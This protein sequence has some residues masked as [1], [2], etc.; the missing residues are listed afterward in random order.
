M[1]DYNHELIGR[2]AEQAALDQALAAVRH[3]SGGIVLLAGAAGVGKTW[4]LD[5]C[6]DRSGL[7]VLRGRAN[8]IATPP[9]GP[10]AGALR[11]YLRARPDGLASTGPLAPYLALLLPELGAPPPD[12]DPAVLVE[13]VCQAFTAIA[14]GTPPVL[15]LDDLQWADNATLELVPALASALEH[16]RVLVVG[17]YRN[18]EIGRGHP[19]RRLRNDLRRAHF[20]REIVVEPL[21]RAETTALAARTFGR[22]P[23]P[24]LAATLYDRTEG[25]PLFVRELAGALALRGRL[26]ASDAGV[27]L[28]PGQDMPIPDTLR[29]AVLLRLDGLPDPALRLLHLAAVAGREFDLAMV[30]ELGGDVEG[31]TEGFDTLFE[32][33]LLVEAEPGR[34]AFRHTL[35]REAVYGDIS[36]V[37]R[38]ALHRRLAEH[39]QAEG[40]AP[41]TV[42]EHWLAAQ[43]PE[44]A[45][46]ALLAASEQACTIHAYRDAASAAQRALELWPDGAEEDSRIDV[47]DRLGQCAQISGMPAEAA[48]AWSE[49]AD[50]HRQG[51][52]LRAYAETERK[53]AN[54]AE[55]QGHWERALAAREAAAR[56]FAASGLPAEAAAERLAAA[57]HLRSAGHY[58]QALELLS[59]AEDEAKQAGRFDLQARVMGLQGNVHARLGQVPEGLALVQKGL[60]LALE[61]NVA[62]AVAEIYQRLADSLEHSGD[63]TGARETYL[64]AFG[65]CQ[66]NAIPATAQLCV[67]CLTVV[68]RQTGE[69]ERAMTMCREVLSSPHSS[70]HARA[71]AG[72]MLGSLYAL[73]GQPG[74]ARPFLLESAALSQRIELVG[75]ELL[76]AWG[77]ALLDEQDG[78]YETAA[79]RYYSILGRWEQIEDTHYV[80][81]TLRWAV[82]FFAMSGADAGA[83]ACALALARIAGTNGQPE[84]LSALA[85]ALGEI[86]L[87]DGDAGQAVQQFRQALDLLREVAVPYCHA[88]TQWRA[89]IACAAAGRR[90]AAVDHLVNAHR[91]ARRLGA[92]PLATRIARALEELGEPVAERLGQGAAGRLRSGDLT[93]RQREILQLVARGQTNAEIAEALVLSPRTVEMHVGNILAA[94]D[95]RTR[96]E[97]VRRATEMGL[98]EIYSTAP[99]KIP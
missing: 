60:A 72:G 39:L 64:T 36:W 45:R 15:V 52:D 79:E 17:T 23:G 13:A 86:A 21:D 42:A 71:V 31:S 51:G 34:G 1:S 55:L 47:L 81:S 84:A 68:L 4:L 16:E 26:V 65:F 9:Y 10:I 90:D 74:R 25:V 57:A 33:G 27:E 96:A 89:G 20:L 85:H 48:R 50:A 59:T 77:L 12:T 58:H 98:L 46:A 91:T 83:R 63:Y 93:R 2:Q 38:R 70:V 92:R 75:M 37:R 7:P 18:D 28:A 35:T 5:A 32:R 66:A 54:V 95:S 88:T 62:G 69:W 11:A 87:L 99:G 29:D 22:P 30:A 76:T 14:R 73:R 40:A 44:R 6:L 53:L 24:A 94:L 8:E 61:H 56:S 80:L 49:V 82:S 19:L 78:A 43:E 97:A 41:L 67:A 3:G